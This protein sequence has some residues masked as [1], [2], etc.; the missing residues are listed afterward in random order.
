MVYGPRPYSILSI[1]VHVT[2]DAL[3][4]SV[5]AVF[6]GEREYR[7]F[8]YQITSPLSIYR[9]FTLVINLIL[10]PCGLD[11]SPSRPIPPLGTTERESYT[12]P[13]IPVSY[14]AEVVEYQLS[15][16][17]VLQSMYPLHSE[18][19]MMPYSQ[20]IV[21]AL[22]ADP[23]AAVRAE[24]IEFIHTTSIEQGEMDIIIL[25]PLTRSRIELNLRQP[26][27]LTRAEWEHVRALPPSVEDELVVEYLQETLDLIRHRVGSLLKFKIQAAQ[28]KAQAE[29]AADIKP[30]IGGQ[31][32]GSISG[33]VKSCLQRVWF[34]F[35]SLS[36]K[37]KRRDLITFGEEHLLTGFLLAGM[38]LSPW[39]LII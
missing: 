9:L 21:D 10:Q 38:S 6:T 12:M 35:P 5:R 4:C 13:A 23:A 34:W 20:P 1:E 37:E 25:L 33:P 18:L 22:E 29:A 27:W 15:N 14:K 16:I 3:P 32:G 24:R 30:D 8:R 36:S 2:V 17:S 7:K 26:A 11:Q 39:P 28:A 19:A 31:E